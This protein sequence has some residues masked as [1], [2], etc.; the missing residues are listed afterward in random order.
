MVRDFVH[1]SF[2]SL[3]AQAGVNVLIHRPTPF[4]VADP[5]DAT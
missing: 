5:P 4:T 2:E 1:G 3:P